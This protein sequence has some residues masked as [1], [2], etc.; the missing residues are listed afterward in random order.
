MVFFLI[1]CHSF[2]NALLN[3]PKCLQDSRQI[4]YIYIQCKLKQ[5]KLKN[6]MFRIKMPHTL[7][8]SVKKSG[9][10]YSFYKQ[11]KLCLEKLPVHIKTFLNKE[12]YAKR[13]K[14]YKILFVFQ[15]FVLT[16]DL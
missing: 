13:Q 3:S 12:N 14:P 9:K 10:R 15:C 4:Q 7:R 11:I 5:E 6:E 8:K 2:F 1:S 16:R